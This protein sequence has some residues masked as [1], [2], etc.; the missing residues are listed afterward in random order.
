MDTLRHDS[1]TALSE[2]TLVD[3][4]LRDHAR[5][6]DV[7]NIRGIP[8]DVAS[9]QRVSLSGLPGSPQGDVDVLLWPPGRADRAV[10]VETK[11][12]KA[13]VDDRP[14]NRANGLREFEKAVRQANLLARL[15]FSQVWLWIFVLVD[16]RARN[17]RQI[18]YRGLPEELR[19]EV[20]RTVSPQKLDRR[21]GLMHYEFVQPMDRAPLDGGTYQA[22]LEQ[23]ATEVN[24]ADAV[25]TWVKALSANL[26]A[27][28]ALEP[29]ART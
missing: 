18:N 28:P 23:L 15:G 9:Q 26:L 3:R 8:E 24:Q 1:L 29:T 11:R 2:A 22:H 10:A 14:E 17:A 13:V 25:T 20:C 6:G 4:L 19:S 27:N 7:L 5:R 21:V 12:F 16:S